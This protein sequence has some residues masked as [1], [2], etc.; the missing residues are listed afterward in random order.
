MVT[1]RMGFSISSCVN[2]GTSHSLRICTFHPRFHRYRH[3]L[4]FERLRHRWSKAPFSLPE[5]F[6]CAV[7]FPPGGRAC[8]LFAGLMN[9]FNKRLA[10]PIP[11]LRL[12]FFRSL[13]S[14]FPSA[15]LAFLDSSLTSQVG[16]LRKA[17]QRAP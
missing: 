9:A 13:L 14:V 12:F 17:F 5:L 4:S 7:T 10:L 15:C 6:V 16:C 2:F 8:Q 11:L 1:G 3:L